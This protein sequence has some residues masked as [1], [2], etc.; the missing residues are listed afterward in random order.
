MTTPD[1]FGFPDICGDGLPAWDE[2]HLPARGTPAKPLISDPPPWAGPAVFLE[3][4]HS[5]MTK[6]AFCR[7]DAFG[8]RGRLFACECGGPLPRSTPPDRRTWITV[9]R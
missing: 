1:W 9:S 8:Y 5:C 4:P 7:S 2:S 6:M 3:R